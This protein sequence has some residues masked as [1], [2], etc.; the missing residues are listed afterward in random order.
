[1]T[2]GQKGKHMQRTIYAGDKTARISFPLGGIGTGS[3]G[4][5]GNGRLL[6]WEIYNRPAKGSLNGYTHFA[7]KV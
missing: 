2:Q 4:L 6:D 3:I 5:G 1:M 7:L